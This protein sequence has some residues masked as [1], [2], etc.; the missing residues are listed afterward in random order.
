MSTPAEIRRR[1]CMECGHLCD[2][3]AEFHPFLFCQLKKA[4]VL[5]PW[6]AFRTAVRHL[7]VETPAKPPL[8]RD[9]P[10]IKPK[11]KRVPQ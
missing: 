11:R 3:E 4:G 9:L 10:L 5:D 8:V 2:R 7:G 6:E 1:T